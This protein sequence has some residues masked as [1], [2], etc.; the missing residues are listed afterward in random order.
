MNSIFD[1]CLTSDYKIL[2][3]KFPFLKWQICN[4]RNWRMLSINQQK[5]INFD[6]IN[7]F[8]MTDSDS[9]NDQLNFLTKFR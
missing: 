7:F 9:I 6:F 3:F 1:I 4:N 2:I 8:F 5:S